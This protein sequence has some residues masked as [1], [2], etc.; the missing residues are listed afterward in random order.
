MSH[1]S[2][3]RPVSPPEPVSRVGS[4]PAPP[5]ADHRGRGWEPSEGSHVNDTVAFMLVRLGGRRFALD[6]RTVQ[7]VA[8]KGAVTRV[9]TAARHVLGVASLRGSLVPVVSLEHMLGVAGPARSEAVTT[10]PRL[11][12]VRAGEYE[13]ALVVDEI[14]GI[15]EERPAAFTTKVG[16]AGRPRFLCEEFAWR[17]NLVCV[18]DVPLLV[19]TAAGRSQ[20][21]D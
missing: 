8:V 21:G 18:L 6:T 12:V 17:G 20:G 5:A 16:S 9:P 2:A 3:A 7:E 13:V 10:L 19:A 4:P 15:V 14:C 1:A 11:V